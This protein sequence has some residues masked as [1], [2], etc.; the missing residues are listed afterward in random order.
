MALAPESYLL[1]K[2]ARRL[3]PAPGAPPLELTGVPAGAAKGMLA[4]GLELAEPGAVAEL[5]LLADDNYG[6]RIRLEPGAKRFPLDT[7]ALGNGAHTVALLAATKSGGHLLSP[8]V[9]L[10][11]RNPYELLAKAMVPP[12]QTGGLARKVHAPADPSYGGQL[13]LES[14]AAYTSGR[15]LQLRLRLDQ[16]SDDWNPPHGYDHVY[17]NVLF[18]FPGQPGRRF[19][20]KLGY[21]RPDFEFNAGFLLYGWGIRSFGAEDSTPEAY[22]A[23]LLGDVTDQADP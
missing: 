19:F 5:S 17:F 11:V 22:G 21:S 2:G 1:V 15:D 3:A 12:E 14:V 4:L 20:P 23:P 10:K 16:V 7:A 9:P 8:A 6:R 13:S 18:D